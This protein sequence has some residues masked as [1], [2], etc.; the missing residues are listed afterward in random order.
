MGEFRDL[1]LYEE[2][3]LDWMRTATIFFIA[4]IALYHFTTKGKPYTLIAFGLSIILI[5]TMII[6]SITRRKELKQS[7][8]H[9][10]LALDVI[11]GVMIIALGLVLWIAYEVMVEPSQNGLPED[12]SIE[13]LE[14]AD[15]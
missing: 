6:D 7:G 9:P 15:D 8:L 4:G 10:R 13:A 12:P 2:L 1:E 11:I 5:V 14:L 3:L